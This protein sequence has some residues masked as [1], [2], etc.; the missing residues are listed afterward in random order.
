MIHTSNITMNSIDYEEGGRVDGGIR[1]SFVDAAWK[2]GQIFYKAEEGEKAFLLGCDKRTEVLASQKTVYFEFSLK[3][4][5][6]KNHIPI[7]LN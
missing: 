1:E 4:R 3:P 7:K 2:N 6:Y 5:S